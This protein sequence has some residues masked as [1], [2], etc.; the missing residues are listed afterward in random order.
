[1]PNS[2]DAKK[3]IA[4][5]IVEAEGLTRI[6]EVGGKPV[7]AL[8]RVD[9]TVD[10]GESVAIM[11]PSGSGKSTLMH[12]LGCLDRPTEGRYRL[13]GQDVMQLSDADLSLIRATQIGFVFQS[14]NL[15]NQYNVYENVA[16]PFLYQTSGRADAWERSVAAIERVGLSHRIEHHP[17]ELSGG[18]IQRVAIARAL[19]IDPALIL[20]DEPTGNLDSKTGD[21]ILDLFEE[22][23]SQ[24][25]TLVIV[26]HDKRVGERCQRV[27]HMRDGSVAPN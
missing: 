23:N 22:L 25:V 18:E 27:V 8:R 19:A 2:S 12:L 4:P 26:T 3:R 6:Y 24:G 7:Y 14:F 5:S 1:M 17:R 16:L 13:K 10:A 15:I 11:G 9:L 21:Q 20:A